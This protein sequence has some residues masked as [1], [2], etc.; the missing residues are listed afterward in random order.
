MDLASIK[1]G[2]MTTRAA[3]QELFGGGTQGGIIPS[4][5]TPNILIYVDH[6]SGKKYG[7]EDGWLEEE[8]ER[9]PVFEYTGQGTRGE[10]TFLGLN[11]SR[12]AAVLCHADTG[13]SLRVFMAAGKVPGSK[14]AAK[15]QRYV[16]EFELDS[17]QPYTV[18][19]ANDEEGKRRRIIVF[20]LRPRGDF[21]RLTQDVIS[22]A[23]ETDTQMVSATVVTCK[24]VEPKRK[25]VSESRRAAQPS[26]IADLR[27]SALRD[28]YLEDLTKREH[29]VFAYQIK[30]SGTT[31]TL[32]TDLYD[33]TTHE[34]HAIRGAS[35]RD[36]LHIA[37]G[38]LKDFVRHIKPRDPKLTVLLPE[39]PQGD[40]L[41]LL[42]TEGI[43]LV[44]QDTHG[45]TRCSAK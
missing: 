9:G 8:D 5:T 1:P 32:K 27:Q 10:Q 18:R 7:Y 39:K 20:R 6:D 16:G 28:Q 42:H 3:M 22:R 2:L 31:K 24:M 17:Q 37:I 4:N 14:S 36:E 33:A 34:L 38:Q 21:E 41:D 13:R 35:S 23:Q 11:G 43:D 29:K 25:R 26:L 19:E 40:L 44:Y 30:I 45:Y 15:R 12:N